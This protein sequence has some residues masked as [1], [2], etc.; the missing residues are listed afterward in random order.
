MRTRR[1]LSPSAR[2]DDGHAA[3]QRLVMVTAAVFCILLISWSAAASD[4]PRKPSVLRGVSLPPIAIDVFA[5]IEVKTSFVDRMCAETDEIW[6]PTGITF[7]WH[8]VTPQETSHRPPRLKV[9]IEHQRLNVAQNH[10]ALGWINFMGSDPEPPIHLSIRG[11]GDLLASTG[12]LEDTAFAR[13]QMLIE[14]ALGRALS[15]ELGHYLLGSKAHASQGLMRASWP[16]LEIFSEERKGF[17]LT[18]E[19]QNA[20]LQRAKSESHS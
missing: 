20:A 7:M 18:A 4:T 5:P 11:A 10:T 6:R 3:S 13:H 12:G 1:L 15:H 8:H 9:V 14:R 17:E 19:E 16:P 2:F